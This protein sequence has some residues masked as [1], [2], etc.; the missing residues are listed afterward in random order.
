MT[1]L[2]LP[3]QSVAARLL[4]TEGKERRGAVYVMARA[5]HR[6]GPETPLEMLNRPEGFFAFLPDGS[7]DVQLISRAQTIS[8]SIPADDPA[9]HPTPMRLT[10]TRLVGLEVKLD[11]GKSIAGHA[12]LELPQHQSRVI[13]YLNASPDPFFA[14]TADGATHFVNRAHV[15]YVLPTD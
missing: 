4:L 9:A 1:G 15:L 14:V 8:L 10:G 11:T 2:S 6:E 12:S 13:D 3:R 7:K 5:P